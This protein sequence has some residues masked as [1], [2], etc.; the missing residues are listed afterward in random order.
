MIQQPNATWDAFQTHTTSKDVIY[1]MSSELVPNATSDQ[2]TK[3]HS[4]E[5]HIKEQ[6]KELNKKVNQSSSQLAHADNKSRQKMTNFCSY[7]QRNG[8]TLMSCRTKALD[9]QIKR[10]QTRNNQE[11]RTV[12][13]HDYIK[14]RGPNFGYQNNQNFNQQPRYGNQN[15]QKP[16]Q[17]NGFNPDRN[18]NPN[19]DRQNQP[20]KSSNSCSNGPNNRQQTHYNF[21]ARLQNS[22]TQHNCN[23]PQNNNLPT[24]NSVQF[25]DDHDTNMINDLSFRN[26]VG[27]RTSHLFRFQ[28]NYDSLCCKFSLQDIEEQKTSDLKPGKVIFM[29]KTILTIPNV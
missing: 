15:N 27:Q 13:T 21:N 1:T 12:F 4:L 11:R 10:Q 18:R 2:N 29:L 8:H 9:D 23:F 28:N 19:S 16:Y 22:D 14:R 26:Q 3:L 17:Q 20:D 7:C 25:I 6:I 5:Q 24:P